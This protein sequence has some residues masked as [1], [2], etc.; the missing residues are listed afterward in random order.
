VDTGELVYLALRFLG[1]ANPAFQQGVAV[2]EAAALQLH[3]LPQRI[4]AQGITLVEHVMT[5][6]QSA[7]ET[8]FLPDYYC[9]H[10][11]RRRRHHHH[12][13]AALA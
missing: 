8:P 12:P 1:A 6:M 10:C 11:C 9:C 13:I 7:L 2:L 3:L 5:H 4:D